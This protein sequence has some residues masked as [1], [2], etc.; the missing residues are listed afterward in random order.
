LADNPHYAS[1]SNR[2]E[3]QFT[4]LRRFCCGGNDHELDWAPA[5]LVRRYNVQRNGNARDGTVR[6][7]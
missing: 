2:I 1:W 4:A 7:L 6:E 3:A 5:L